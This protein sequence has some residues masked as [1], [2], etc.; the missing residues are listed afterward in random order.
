[1]SA[2]NQGYGLRRE[3]VLNMTILATVAIVLSALFTYKLME[4]YLLFQEIENA[5]I[6][7]NSIR[8]RV[9]LAIQQGNLS[10]SDNQMI[11]QQ[12]GQFFEIPYLKRIIVVD[13][14]GQMVTQLG[15]RERGEKEPLFGDDLKK[16]LMQA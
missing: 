12:L 10:A 13:E 8:D 5:K 14:R 4:R 1:M 2:Q 7:S 6:F 11:W 16:L 15:Q 3:I 9:Q